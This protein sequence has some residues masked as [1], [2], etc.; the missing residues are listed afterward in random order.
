LLFLVLSEEKKDEKAVED[1]ESDKKKQ[2]RFVQLYTSKSYADRRSQLLRPDA[3]AGDEETA[4][5]TVTE[6]PCSAS[7]LEKH[8]LSP[9]LVNAISQS[10]QVVWANCQKQEG[11]LGRSDMRLQTAVGMPV[12]VDADGNMC[13]VV[14]FS[15]E[16]LEST[17]DAMEYLQFISKSATSSSIPCL[18]PVFDSNTMKPA[19]LPHPHNDDDEK[20]VLP[21]DP[22]FGEGVTA[23]YVSIDDADGSSNDPVAHGVSTILAARNP[24]SLFLFCC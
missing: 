4:H 13:I 19:L 22:S 9:Q 5:A 23:H 3:D 18:L 10:A 17:D 11:L 14:M 2:L 12:A 21:P 20:H 1:G 24:V 16:N 7:D 15:P 8:V 6:T